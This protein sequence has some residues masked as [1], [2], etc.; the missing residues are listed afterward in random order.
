MSSKSAQLTTSEIEKLVDEVGEKIVLPI[1]E[2]PTIATVTDVEKLLGQPFFR[3]AKNGDKVMIFSSTKE[4]ILYRPSIKKIITTTL[5]N[6]TGISPAPSTNPAQALTTPGVSTT[7]TPPPQ[8]TP[9]VPKIKVT[10]LNSTKEAGLAKRG[11]LLL[12]KEKFEVV[13]TTNAQ[14]EYEVT[15]ISTVSKNKIDASVK[16]DVASNFS[17]VKVI[18]SSLP[19]DETTPTGVELVIILGSDFAESY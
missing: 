6:D 1:G 10:V 14:G 19:A 2:P 18:E 15:T 9:K 16:K 7:L 12:D 5:I 3:N 13:S 4:A 11:A 8:A 17:K